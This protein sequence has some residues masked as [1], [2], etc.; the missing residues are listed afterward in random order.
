MLCVVC[1]AAVAGRES[2]VSSCSIMEI[3]SSMSRGVWKGSEMIQSTGLS[4]HVRFLNATNI[5]CLIQLST[6]SKA[7]CPPGWDAAKLICMFNILPP[8]K[9]ILKTDFGDR[10]LLSPPQ[11]LFYPTQ[12]SP[13]DKNSPHLNSK[14]VMRTLSLK[15]LSCLQFLIKL[16]FFDCVLYY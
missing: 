14:L 12:D 1:V 6:T 9:G 15:S 11:S 10:R 13:C 7:Q 4:M 2:Q 3:F 8:R 16:L 5:I